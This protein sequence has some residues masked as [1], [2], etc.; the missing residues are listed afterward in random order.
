MEHLDV[1]ESRSIYIIREAY[2][3][4][5]R[6]AM[7]RSIGKDS[8]TLLWLCKKSFFGRIPFPVVY[9]DTGPHFQQMY[10]FHDECVERRGL[11]LIVSKNEKADESGIGPQDK[12]K[13]CDARKTQALKKTMDEHGFD[14]LLPGIRRDEHG[15]RAKERVFSPRDRDFTWDYKNQPP[16]LWDQ[17]KTESESH[18]HLRVHPLLHRTR[19]RSGRG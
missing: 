19:W 4:F 18:E 6:V 11:D 15:I 7:P 3:K 10:D 2:K 8:T 5:E 17:Y 12:I 9:I 16:E 1:L 14:A 13:C